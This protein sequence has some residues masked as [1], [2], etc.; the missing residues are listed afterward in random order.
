MSSAIAYRGKDN[1]WG[2][3]TTFLGC[4]A[5]PVSFCT[6]NIQTGFW[7]HTQGWLLNQLQHVVQ[8]P[9]PLWAVYPPL[10][11]QLLAAAQLYIGKHRK[12]V[13]A[14]VK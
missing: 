7:A 11:K 9:S 12:D 1:D 2:L 5:T 3:S 8:L 10:R 13:C 4:V 6:G 14:E